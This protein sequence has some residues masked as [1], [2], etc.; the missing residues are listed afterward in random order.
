MKLG[1]NM[2]A[3]RGVDLSDSLTGFVNGILMYFILGN[4]TM[5]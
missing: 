2:E 4:P 3:D 1:G 5:L